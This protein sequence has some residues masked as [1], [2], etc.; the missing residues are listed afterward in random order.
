MKI[1]GI[2]GSP[3]RG[4]NTELLLG[5]FLRGCR[6]EG[7]EVEEF[8]LR[9]LKISPCLEIYACKKDGDCP[10]KDDM[11]LL[12]AKFAEADGVAM[13]TPIFFYAVSAQLKAMI[14]RCQAMW[15]RKYILHQ[16][17]SPG[18]TNRRGVFLAVGGSKGGKIFDGPLLTMKYFFDALD[19]AFYRSLLFKEIDAKGDILKH[20]T[21]MAEAFALGREFVKGEPPT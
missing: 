18:K 4:G 3:R 20:P 5:E 6:E 7:A 17:I 8:H 19:V 15:A 9:D 2:N 11:K 13:A 1:V 16:T 12:Y 21:A 10:I 14:D